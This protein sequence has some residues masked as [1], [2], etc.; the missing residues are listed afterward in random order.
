LANSSEREIDGG[1]END[2]IRGTAR[3]DDI[4]GKGGND[5][6]RGRAGNDELDGGFGHDKLFGAA[7]NDDLD[8]ESGNDSLF[9]GAGHD[10]LDGGVGND[11]LSGGAG[12]DTFSFE[13]FDGKD[14]VKDF[15]IGTDRVEIDIDGIRDFGDLTIRNN[16][17]GAAVV[18]WGQDGHSVTLKGVDAA[19]LSAADFLFDL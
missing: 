13:R 16:A 12:R 10:W 15:T 5:E 17:K 1:P 8:G 6:L 14:V 11:V 2:V 3:P 9:G 19:S 7:G 18:S 4:D